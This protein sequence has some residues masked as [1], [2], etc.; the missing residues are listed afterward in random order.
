MVVAIKIEIYGPIFFTNTDRMLKRTLLPVWNIYRESI[1][2]YIKEELENFDWMNEDERKEYTYVKEVLDEIPD[3]RTFVKNE[4]KESVMFILIIEALNQGNNKKSSIDLLTNYKYLLNNW[5]S[6]VY[7]TKETNA[8][9][10]YDNIQLT[11]SDLSD[12][13]NAVIRKNLL[14]TP[15]LNTEQKKMLNKD[16]IDKLVAIKEKFDLP[17]RIRTV[18]TMVDALVQEKSKEK[19]LNN[20]KTKNTEFNNRIKILEYHYK[21][22]SRWN[23]AHGCSSLFGHPEQITDEMINYM[24]QKY[25]DYRSHIEKI[26]VMTNRNSNS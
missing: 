19:M 26:I 8:R 16:I 14:T 12:Y 13:M 11:N 5:D 15:W 18:Y 22:P 1:P 3:S 2:I 6:F 23:N 4:D 20:T 25:P 17:H 7:R 21:Y 24:E 10:D 9:A